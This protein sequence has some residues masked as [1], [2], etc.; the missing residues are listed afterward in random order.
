MFKYRT[1]N[2]GEL[3][4]SN[5]NNKVILFGWVNKIRIMKNFYFIDIR[6][7]YGITQLLIEKKKIKN[8]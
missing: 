8:L 5:I 2:C 7:F 1:H 3:N 6:D 4:L